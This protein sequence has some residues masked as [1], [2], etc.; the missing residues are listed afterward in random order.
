MKKI[1]INYLKN[2]F[3][4]YYNKIQ[5]YYNIFIKS[6]VFFVD[7]LYFLFLNPIVF[8]L[9]LLLFI[10]LI[11]LTLDIFII[12]IFNIIKVIFSFCFLVF[13]KFFVIWYYTFLS[14]NFF[15]YFIL[16]FFKFCYLFVY[17]FFVTLIGYGNQVVLV[18]NQLILLILFYFFK[19]FFDCINL[20]YY[21]LGFLQDC[22]N[23]IKVKKL[24]D[25][26][27]FRSYMFVPIQKCWLI[28]YALVKLFQVNY[29]WNYGLN[30]LIG[31]ETILEIYLLHYLLVFLFV[32]SQS[33]YYYAYI[34]LD[35]YYQ[36]LYFIII[37]LDFFFYY[38]LIKKCLWKSWIFLYVYTIYLHLTYLPNNY[39]YFYRIF[40]FL[41][42]DINFPELLYNFI[43]YTFYYIYSYQY[44]I[45]SVYLPFFFFLCILYFYKWYLTFIL[46]IYSFVT[47][48]HFY[49][50]YL[51][52]V[53]FLLLHLYIF[54]NFFNVFLL[55]K[56]FIFIGK[57]I[58]LNSF[59]F[60][61][62]IFFVC[63]YLV[64]FFKLDLQAFYIEFKKIIF[65]YLLQF[66]NYNLIIKNYILFFYYR[67]GI[68]LAN[69]VTNKFN[70][71][72]NTPSSIYLIKQKKNYKNL[73]FFFDIFIYLY[74][75]FFVYFKLNSRMHFQI[76]KS[77]LYNFINKMVF[78]FNFNYLYYLYTFKKQ[79][80]FYIINF[81]NL[82]KLSNFQYNFY[83][84]LL[85]YTYLY[86]LVFFKFNFY[87]FYFARLEFFFLN[88]FSINSFLN[89]SLK[90]YLKMSV[91]FKEEKN[92]LL[93]EQKK[94]FSLKKNPIVK[95]TVSSFFFNQLSYKLFY[96]NS[97]YNYYLLLLYK[98]FYSFD[99]FKNEVISLFYNSDFFLK[100]INLKNT[101]LDSISF[102]S[103]QIFNSFFN[104]VLFF[105]PV[106][107]YEIS[108]VSS[109][110]DVNLTNTFL[111]DSF[112]F[113]VSSFDN[114]YLLFDLALAFGDDIY[115]FDSEA[116]LTNRFY[117]QIERLEDEYDNLGI[118]YDSHYFFKILN[119]VDYKNFFFFKELVYLNVNKFLLVFLYDIITYF[120][121]NNFYL[122]KSNLFLK[123]FINP[124]K[125]AY[126]YVLNLLSYQTINLWDYYFF[127]LFESFTPAIT[128][129]IYLNNK[130]KLINKFSVND[131]KNRNVLR[132]K[133]IKKFD[134]IENREYN[135]LM[136]KTAHSS[137]SHHF[138]D[139]SFLHNYEYHEFVTPWHLKQHEK[140]TVYSGFEYMFIDNYSYLYDLD[141]YINYNTLNRASYFYD[142]DIFS[143]LYFENRQKFN[144]DILND[145]FFKYLDSNL[146][147]PVLYE[148]KYHLL[149]YHVDLTELDDNKYPYQFYS[150]QDLSQ[151]LFLD[152][153]FTLTRF[154]YLY[155]FTAGMDLNIY[156]TLNFM[157]PVDGLMA[158]ISNVLYYSGI[159]LNIMPK[160]EL[161][162]YDFFFDY[163]CYSLKI[164]LLDYILFYEY[165]IYLN[166]TFVF[167]PIKSFLLSSVK[168]S[169]FERFKFHYYRISNF[170]L[171]PNNFEP[172]VFTFWGTKFF[173]G[174]W[175][176]L[177]FFFF[178][179]ILKHLFFIYYYINSYLFGIRHI[180]DTRLSF[181]NFFFFL[182]DI[183]NYKDFS[184]FVLYTYDNTD[185]YE[186]YFD[187]DFMV[188]S[189]VFES[190]GF[191]AYL[192]DLDNRYFLNDG[193]L[194][195]LFAYQTS[196]FVRFYTYLTFFYDCFILVLLQT[197][198]FFYNFFFNIL[199][200]IKK[201]FKFFLNFIEF[202]LF[203]TFSFM[204]IS[205]LL[206]VKFLFLIFLLGSFVSE[207][208]IKILQYFYFFDFLL[209]IN[210]IL[211]FPFELIR[212]IC[213]CCF[214]YFFNKTFKYYKYV[215]QYFQWFLYIFF[216]LSYF[217]I[218][219]LIKLFLVYIII[220]GLF[221]NY[222]NLVLLF[223]NIF[224]IKFSYRTIFF[225]YIML[226][227]L[228]IV[229]IL[230]PLESSN[231]LW[232]YR[233]LI[234]L[235]ALTVWFLASFVN[236][237]DL[238]F[239]TMWDIFNNNAHSVIY[240][241]DF[242]WKFIHK[243]NYELI[244]SNRTRS[245][246]FI[247]NWYHY[248]IHYLYLYKFYYLK[249]IWFHYKQVFNFIYE[250]YY[251]PY[252][253]SL[254]YELVYLYFRL[255]YTYDYLEAYYKFFENKKYATV[256]YF[257]LTSTEKFAAWYSIFSLHFLTFNEYFFY[258]TI[259]NTTIFG[260]SYSHLNLMNRTSP[261]FK[262]FLF[263]KLSYYKHIFEL[264][265]NS[266]WGDYNI[267][268]SSFFIFYRK[269]WFMSE[270]H[271]FYM[272]IVNAVPRRRAVKGLNYF[273][274]PDRFI[275]FKLYDE[276]LYND[277]IA[278]DLPDE[279]TYTYPIKK[280]S[281]I[282]RRGDVQ[283]NHRRYNSSLLYSK[284]LLP[285][286]GFIGSSNW[287]VKWKFLSFDKA[288]RFDSFYF[289]TGR[290]P[291][292]R[293]W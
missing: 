78:D 181:K 273:R 24:N 106:D 209:V 164:L 110:N 32:K 31:T 280:A 197:I 239:T 257:Y 143:Y 290:K 74:I 13:I 62:I 66:Y 70:V 69:F 114:I 71:V 153:R 39:D 81:F 190:L 189:K 64:F 107:Y 270:K 30:Y 120:S 264:T 65:C 130:F 135:Y 46:F 162:L 68:I 1:F 240:G 188:S 88:F 228:L 262:K 12:L 117:M 284:Y 2:M 136:S 171:D 263:V 116:A 10:F 224:Y 83:Y 151:G 286:I 287:G 216:K 205:Y 50:F 233:Y 268:P 222:D 159:T 127:F 21:Y 45:F 201:Y 55:L 133:E 252:I 168:L 217:L 192:A 184:D 238:Y 52:V 48:L 158:N 108:N 292:R 54:I 223:E 121:Y 261:N 23:F 173:Y 34:C 20:I 231:V 4:Y 89:N 154:S 227:F 27:V 35:I 44:Y 207:L 98:T 278:Y 271:F 91:F 243:T 90:N 40:L 196:G 42:K 283:Y 122:I 165:G 176:Q 87:K 219:V 43:N 144:L 212:Y 279:S 156:N 142:Q 96:N 72:K 28:Y 157:Y 109:L 161:Y 129:N 179:Y 178:F 272:S 149:N 244:W 22:V 267:T 7:I 128:K 247:N 58:V 93:F 289:K 86:K 26:I 112:F 76:K 140:K 172:F 29:Y 6:Y 155:D 206:G 187:Q 82:L 175:F 250:K 214:T 124:E 152:E 274:H 269:K 84:N 215:Y 277:K 47:S 17:S 225:F 160:L 245:R 138:W 221:D 259:A 53:K 113:F 186:G 234:L 8:Y 134:L 145:F 183:F 193:Y 59:F 200:T 236:S 111:V 251:Q 194:S 255:E 218:L 174:Y 210:Y 258:K 208:L 56:I 148:R 60:F 266:L 99:F 80:Y 195:S 185:E 94:I 147:H 73:Y 275:F 14:I 291:F 123:T 150:Y 232:S 41:I 115:D 139:F 38:F 137:L 11:S 198:C 101:S 249:F 37:K 92:F 211:V 254:E 281:P 253:W 119:L 5:F 131:F 118:T 285:D 230:R 220:I 15:F 104:D 95:Y 126:Q 49:L 166:T 170:F 102:L 256:L 191:N 77:F 103:T 177:P 182:N 18:I 100:K 213:V 61:S 97:Y 169:Y 180:F 241:S 141:F 276:I 85:Y 51:Y 79:I 248:N 229:L 203:I 199:N 132:L 75:N 105:F 163:Y 293:H 282:R 9:V 63:F 226:F 19:F 36:I 146:L 57:V 125:I 3:E 33:Y 202:L 25:A 167:G 204:Y 16:V 288:L 260:T 242:Y 246:K 265:R 67:F 237:V 235:C